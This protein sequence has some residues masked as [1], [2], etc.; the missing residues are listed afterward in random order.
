MAVTTLFETLALRAEDPSSTGIELEVIK[1]LLA[2]QLLA[3]VPFKDVNGGAYPYSLEH[4]KPKAYPRL[5]GEE[6]RTLRGSS[7]QMSE[8]FRNYGAEIVTDKSLL[9]LHGKDAHT[10]QVISTSEAIQMQVETDIVRGSDAES[11]GRSFD[12]MKQ[13][14]AGSQVLANT[15][16][17]GAPLSFAALDQLKAAVDGPESQKVLIMPKKLVTL[18]GQAQRTVGT[19]GTVNYQPNE[20]G[21]MIARYGE[22]PILAVDVDS[23]NNDIIPFNEGAN[24]DTCTIYCANFGDKKVQCIQGPSLDENDTPRTGL[25]VYDVGGESF[26]T[27]AKMTRISWHISFV[28]ENPKMLAALS[29]ITLGTI[30]P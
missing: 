11:G 23:D 1:T 21:M 9:A 24:N 12:G 16:G 14:V 6:H 15:S 30:T 10:N 27:P 28:V 3:A 2:G 18:F 29:K 8:T 20:V 13:R 17:A 25:V 7:R 22:T 19:S 4:E 5:I 26:N